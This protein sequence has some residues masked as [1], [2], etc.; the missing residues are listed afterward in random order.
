MK[1]V[2]NF[3]WGL[4]KNNLLLKIMAVL[5]AVVLWSYVLAQ[6]NPMRERTLN[7][8]P[9][10]YDEAVLQDNGLAISYTLSNIV[11]TVDVR[12]EVEQ[13]SAKYVTE[14]NV[15]ANVKLSNVT[16]T[17]KLTFEIEA[18]SP[19]GTVVEV[20]PKTVTLNIDQYIARSLPVLP[21]ITGSV[22]DGY[23]AGD[24]V[25]EPDVVTISGA[26]SDV[27]LASSALCSIDLSGLTEWSKKS[28]DVTILDGDNKALDTKLFSPSV[29]S[30]I[31]DISI[32]PVK[33]VTVDVDN[34][35]IGQDSLAPGYEVTGIECDPATVQIV[36]TAEALEGV[37]SIPLV[38]Y[39]VSGL[40]A[41]AVVQT[42]YL[43][44]EGV[45]VLDSGQVT[46][47]VTIREK[48]TT[49]EFTSVAID[50]RNLDSELTVELS[51]TEVDVTVLAGVS[52]MSTL[53]TSDVVPY[54]DLNGMSEGTYT[55][56]VLFEL[57]N[58]FAS[59]NFTPSV[60]TITVTIT[61]G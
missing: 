9:V 1:K 37:D 53:Q 60:A 6:T 23:Y 59:E 27:N 19:Y 33:T 29:P 32:L 25:F 39:S 11:E 35:I 22:A 28:M 46:V 20:S 34:S 56:D 58:G 7:D 10:N 8:I 18:T 5:F 44:P 51:Q 4:L 21:D 17:G 45:T 42:P 30:V 26:A 16:S 13:N 14:T 54:I 2:L 24:P 41:D 50:V 57:P 47:T 3:I 49:E 52:V 55:V 43:P 31:V 38:P 40:D 36:G 12:V 48:T 61:R 15:T